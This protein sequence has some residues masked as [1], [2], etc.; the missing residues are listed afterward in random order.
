MLDAF[1]E[2]NSLE[3]RPRTQF[4]D[5][6]LRYPT[7]EFAPH[8]RFKQTSQPPIPGPAPRKLK[9]SLD[10]FK[11]IRSLFSHSMI[12]IEYAPRFRKVTFN[13]NP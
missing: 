4:E 1:H 6:I 13:E 5:H 10:H 8:N 7:F 9:L 11:G 2:D 3:G 12:S